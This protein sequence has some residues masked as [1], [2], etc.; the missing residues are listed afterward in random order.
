M[1]R[2]RQSRM[3]V[4][5]SWRMVE[6]GENDS[7]D[8]SVV[9]DPYDDDFVLSSG[10][11]QLSASSQGIG[12]Q[13]S[14]RDFANKADED[15]VILRAPFQ[16]SLVST[17]NPSA[18]KERTPVPEFFMPPVDVDS[19]RRSSGRSSRTIRPATN[20]MSSQVR[21]RDY[22]QRSFDESPRRR[23]PAFVRKQSSGLGSSS[24]PTP[25]QRFAASAPSVLFESAAWTLS[26]LGMALRYAKYPLAGLMAV[27]LIIGVF[28][29][30][31]TMVTESIS[32]SMSPICRIPG[33]SFIDLPFCPDVAGSKNGSEPIEFDDLVTAQDQ[34]EKVLE[35]AA[36]GVSLPMELK[37]SEASVR[38]LRT[39]IR[40]SDLP[41][42]EELVYEFDGYIDT[43]RVISADLQTFNTHV[44]SSVD[45]VISIN[46]W[47]SRYLDTIASNREA[48]DNLLSRGIEWIFSPFQ[49]AVFDERVLLE[50]YIEHTALVSEKIANLIVEAQAALR[51]LNQAE[52]H[53][54]L[55]KEHCVRN[56]Q[57]VVDQKNDV[58]W[59]IWTLLGAN[60]S[61]LRNLKTQISL[62]RQ[63]EGQRLSAV[64]RLN[65]LI[66]DLTTIQ[67]QLSDLRD[68]VA[69]PEL[70]A[71]GSTI[72]LSV[73]IETI[74]AGVERL[75]AA[76]SRIRAEEN[77]R[78]QQALKRAREEDRLIDG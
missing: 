41:G 63:V 28:M 22:R 60:N 42:R 71:D 18:D 19:P 64:K 1:A 38:D 44:G 69:T 6:E 65:V 52:N 68:R 27:Y 43:I 49:P 78:L 46:R 53:L 15:Q 58:F 25:S 20:D 13:D 32:A 5:G 11:S 3:P 34:F 50:K 66:H 24:H 75:E 62:L 47:T 67:S 2:T 77:D 29:L 8:T 54:D 76:R 59:S 35:E 9:H 72:P 40:F 12:S 36:S 31:K 26:I 55:I 14:I 73:H 45:S 7:F 21:R 51:L 33:V 74:N 70:L 37:R 30:G 56:E 16:P 61:R 39:V 10:Q 23:D 48:N 4:E 17:R 57:V